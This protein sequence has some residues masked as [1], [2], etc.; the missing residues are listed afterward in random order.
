M[1]EFKIKDN[2]EYLDTKIKN[3]NIKNDI[4]ISTILRG[5]NVIFPGGNDVIKKHDTLVIVVNNKSNIKDI[6]DIME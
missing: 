2:F 4:I 5:R 1:I 6:N 3:L